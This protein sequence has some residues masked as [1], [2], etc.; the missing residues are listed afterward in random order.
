LTWEDSEER[1]GVGL[2]A[3]QSFPRMAGK[4][5]GLTW[6]DCEEG[7]GVGS[8]GR[9]ITSPQGGEGGRPDVGGL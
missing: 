1:V 5:A 7:V 8:G 9:A 4:V 6:E 2:A 3:E